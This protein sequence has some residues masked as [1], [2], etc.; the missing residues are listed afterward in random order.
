MGASFYKLS[1]VS[2]LGIKG[3]FEGSVYIS[4]RE[5]KDVFWV[6]ATLELETGFFQ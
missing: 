1:L 2:L 5:I 4:A 6:W 3:V